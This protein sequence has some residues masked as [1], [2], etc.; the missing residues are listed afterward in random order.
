MRLEIDKTAILVHYLVFL[1]VM[2][3]VLQVHLTSFPAVVFLEVMVEV[4][5]VHLTSV[6]VVLFLEVMV[7]VLPVHLLTSF[8]EVEEGVQDV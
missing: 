4:L 6:P 1:E 3:E 7:E 8:P 2:V 5:P